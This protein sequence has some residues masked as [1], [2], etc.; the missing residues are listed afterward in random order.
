MRYNKP[1]SGRHTITCWRLDCFLHVVD[2]VGMCGGIQVRLH[3][4]GSAP[5]SY[6]VR[7]R[8]K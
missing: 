6:K 2:G 4:N 7:P 8:K 3:K 1:L 5:I